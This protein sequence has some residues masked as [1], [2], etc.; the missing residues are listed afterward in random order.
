MKPV[1]Y[2]L[3]G[4]VVRAS[5]LH[6]SR[7]ASSCAVSRA[8]ITV[9]WSNRNKFGDA[10]GIPHSYTAEAFI[11]TRHLYSCHPRHFQSRPI[12]VIATWRHTELSKSSLSEPGST[13]TQTHT[14]THTHT[15]KSWY[16]IRQPKFTA[17][18]SYACLL[19]AYMVKAVILYIYIYYIQIIMLCISTCNFH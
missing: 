2:D 13:N 7:S 16:T 11:M 9:T 15:L 18:V 10:M 8:I 12:N 4:F 19:L 6:C 17:P 3:C 14:H 1:S 5:A